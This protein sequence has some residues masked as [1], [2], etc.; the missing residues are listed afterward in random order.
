MGR[1][2]FI[3]ACLALSISWALAPAGQAMAKPAASFA[4]VAPTRIHADERVIVSARPGK[5]FQGHLAVVELIDPGGPIE[6]ATGYV[7]ADG[8]ARVKVQVPARGAH[9]LQM[10][11]V[12]NR[13]SRAVSRPFTIVVTSPARKLPAGDTAR[14]TRIAGQLMA[15][16]NGGGA[17][18]RLRSREGL[19]AKSGFLSVFVSAVTGALSSSIAKDVYTGALEGAGGFAVTALLNLVFPGPQ[20]ATAAQV[21]ALANQMSADFSQ[22][23][24]ELSQIEAQLNAL[25]QQLTLQIEQTQQDVV[26]TNASA[27]AATCAALTSQAN[28]YVNSIQV[29]FDSYQETLNPT[30]LG[31]NLGANPNSTAGLQVIGNQIFGAGTGNPSFLAGLTG[32][33]QAVSNLG[34]LMSSGGP[35]GSPGIVQACATATSAATATQADQ[36]LVLG[37]QIAPVGA[38]DSAYFG[39]IQ[40]I[41]DYYS[42]WVNIG[43]ALATM[44]S[45]FAIASIS[46]PQ[47]NTAS[48]VGSICQG[49]PAAP[50]PSVITCGGSLNYFDATVA[51]VQQGWNLTGAAWSQVSNG[52]LASDAS[53]S[54]TGLYMTPGSNA[55]T[56]D[57]GDYGYGT[58]TFMT[59]NPGSLAPSTS[60]GS[61]PASGTTQLA[62]STWIGLPFTSAKAAAWDRLLGVAGLAPYPGATLP[63][64][65]ACLPSST[66]V[67]VSCAAPLNVG[68]YMGKAGL[69]TNNA[70]PDDLIVFTGETSTWNTSNSAGS[71]LPLLRANGNMPNTYIPAGVQL[72]TMSF[73]DSELVP[74]QGASAVINTP[75]APAGSITP[76]SIYPYSGFQTTAGAGPNPFGEGGSWNVWLSAQAGGGWAFGCAS[77]PPNPMIPPGLPTSVTQAMSPLLLGEMLGLANGATQQSGNMPCNYVYSGGGSNIPLT[78]N[79]SFYAPL[80]FGQDTA[81]PSTSVM[82]PPTPS[83]PQ[84]GFL[85]GGGISPQVQ[86]L[87]PVVSIDG[88][89]CVLTSFTQGINGN[90]GV[91]NVCQS[92][93]EEWGAVNLG[94][95]YG[96][97][98]IS[99][100][101]AQDTQQLSGNNVAQFALSNT[102]GASQ[103]VTL[104][105]TAKGAAPTPSWATPVDVATPGMGT[106]SINSCTNQALEYAQSSTTCSLIVPPGT[107]MIGIPLNYGSA[108]T[109]T[110]LAS[111]AG[112]GIASASTVAVT[113]APATTGSAPDQ[114][115]GLEVAA[116]P[117]TAANDV[118]LTWETPN[119]ASPL[120]GY[121]LNLTDPLGNASTQSLELA[122]ITPRGTL[123]AATVVLPDDTVG[124]WKFTLAG[125]NVVGTGAAGVV[126]IFLGYG[127]PPSVSNLRAL[128]NPDGTITVS[129]SPIASSP[130]VSNYSVLI[131]YPDGTV[132]NVIPVG[133][134]QYTS[135]A[136][137][138]LGTYQVSVYARNAA[139]AGPVQQTNVTLTGTVPS[140]VPGLD[141]S[142]TADG[143]VSASWRGA[144]GVPTPE[145]YSMVLVNPAFTRVFSQTITVPDVAD[146]VRVPYFF[147][148]AKSSPVGTWYLIVS[149]KNSVGR[150]PLAQGYLVVTSSMLAAASKDREDAVELDRVPE[151]LQAVAGS[152]CSLGKWTP[153]LRVFG[154]CSDK[155][156]TAAR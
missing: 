32:L 101:A 69:L 43:Q 81:N 55:W 152:L 67:V 66:G 155:R 123:S 103:L 60:A 9:E 118:T 28:G 75:G 37:G 87:W 62:Q 98:Q 20:S 154:D 57:I 121:L 129:W 111:I 86:Y 89:G 119:S 107:S 21:Q 59:G 109:G 150:G 51:A 106:V 130:P 47:P 35:G 53:V 144:S 82:T 97:V 1:T 122:D 22:V 153:A 135:Q 80:S 102:T 156:F 68:G 30:W 149:A 58:T 151:D 6:L 77:A 46:Q 65:Q 36:I 5:Q 19:A 116:N 141:L 31:A 50:A 124:N 93:F 24:A 34:A 54:P 71:V 8:V 127:P 96:G 110:I 2:R 91:T 147:K 146:I 133:V 25:D 108:S 132:S 29:A 126:T 114:V 85:T 99:S 16:E 112:S 138:V 56:V 40:M 115:L 17:T 39:S 134:P 73:L 70:V 90:A 64:P 84:P 143:S 117:N 140:A 142:V 45:Q 72:T 49:V 120:T 3:A 61:G 78:G 79:A 88:T 44:G 42:G 137:T 26:D 48:E 145:S 131:G 7:A 139:G 11:V 27:A 100:P 52:I 15:A 128:V 12:D 14:A 104:L 148:L 33:Q 92:A 83:A 38:V 105:V 18:G 4:V 76:S 136:L 41:T 23:E 95:T 94:Q 113:N 13:R 125:E 10:R 63:Q 74:N